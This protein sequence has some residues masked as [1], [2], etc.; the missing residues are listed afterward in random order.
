MQRR[1]RMIE[2]LVGSVYT[3]LHYLQLNSYLALSRARTC[4]VCVYQRLRLVSLRTIELLVEDKCGPFTVVSNLWFTNE[5]FCYCE[6]EAHNEKFSVKCVAFLIFETTEC[7]WIESL[8]G[9]TVKLLCSKFNFGCVCGITLT[10]F[11]IL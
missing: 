7:A 10:F 8:F 2:V 9:S 6:R 5:L 11:M 3:H 1:M 4:V